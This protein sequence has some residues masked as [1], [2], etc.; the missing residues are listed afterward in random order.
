MLSCF[1][2]VKRDILKENHHNNERSFMV[3]YVTKRKESCT[4]YTHQATV[5]N[6]KL[7]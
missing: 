5:R 3:E 1:K 4:K 7:L 6:W 2:E